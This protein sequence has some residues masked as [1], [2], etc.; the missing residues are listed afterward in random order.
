MP[1][2]PDWFWGHKSSGLAR[3]GHS[4]FQLCALTRYLKKSANIARSDG[5]LLLFT[6]FKSGDV[7]IQ[8]RSQIVLR[9]LNFSSGSPENRCGI[10]KSIGRRRVLW[11][12]RRLELVKPISMTIFF[13]C[14]RTEVV[15]RSII[16]FFNIPAKGTEVCNQICTVIDCKTCEWK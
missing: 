14:E 12:S 2:K 6:S 16:H 7:I 15:Y 10:A 3:R 5:T 1:P 9:F 8:N 13:Y 11:F 4:R